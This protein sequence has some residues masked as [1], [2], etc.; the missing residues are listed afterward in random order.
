MSKTKERNHVSKEE[1]GTEEASSSQETSAESSESE[2]IRE[3]DEVKP[4]RDVL[5][6]LKLGDDVFF[7]NQGQ[8]YAAKVTSY[9]A[10]ANG[11]DIVYFDG[12]TGRTAAVKKAVYGIENR[13][14]WHDSTELITAIELER[15]RLMAGI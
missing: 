1:T 14:W 4:K 8:V 6:E 13:Q 3:L 9:G 5:K 15:Q 7:R 2:I 12:S 11:A 10:V